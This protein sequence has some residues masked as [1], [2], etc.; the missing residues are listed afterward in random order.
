VVTAAGRAD[1][2]EFSVSRNV[3]SCKG[4]AAP[5]EGNGTR[6]T[7]ARSSHDFDCGG[8]AVRCCW[9]TRWI[10]LG[11]AGCVDAAVDRRPLPAHAYFGHAGVLA[12]SRQ[13]GHAVGVDLVAASRAE[14]RPLASAPSGRRSGEAAT[15]GHGPRV[16]RRPPRARDPHRQ[17][18][19]YPLGVEPT[20]AMRVA[21]TCR[22][23]GPASAALT[24]RVAPWPLMRS[25]EAHE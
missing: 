13:S 14:R 4:R 21:M 16:S 20:I 19:A 9:R 3:G 11:P 24:T 12:A 25:F 8:T 10:T 22:S 2:I 1:L 15:R 7:P 23:A 6:A 5:P 17:E 18:C